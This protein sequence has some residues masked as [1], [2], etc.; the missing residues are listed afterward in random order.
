MLSPAPLHPALQ[1]V[2]VGTDGGE[3]RGILGVLDGFS[4]LGV[5]DEADIKAR[6][7]LLRMIGYKR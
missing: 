7:D 1:A 5:E 3:R 6:K 2:V 4:P